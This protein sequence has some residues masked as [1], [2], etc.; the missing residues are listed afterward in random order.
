MHGGRV[1]IRHEQRPRSTAGP[2]IQT[3]L[4]T[5]FPLPLKE[6]LRL[7]TFKSKSGT[8]ELHLPFGTCAL[9]SKYCRDQNS[10][11]VVLTH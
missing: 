2:R 10:V 4:A 7:K 1:W 9:L 6:A 3:L 8:E 11:N 5:S